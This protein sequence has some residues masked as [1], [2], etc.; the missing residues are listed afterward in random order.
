MNNSMKDNVENYHNS[1]FRGELINSKCKDGSLYDTIS[2]GTFDDVYVGDYYQMSFLD[3]VINCRIAGFDLFYN[4]IFYDIGVLSHHAVIVPDEILMETPMHYSYKHKEYVET[5]LKTMFLPFIYN[6]LL[7]NDRHILK[8]SVRLM[9]LSEIYGKYFYPYPSLC[10][11]M[12]KMD[13]EEKQ[14]PL[15]RLNKD[16]ISNPPRKNTLHY[17]FWIYQNYY[18]FIYDGFPYIRLNNSFCCGIRPCWLIG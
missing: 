13:L 1:K 5:S 10:D 6:S 8:N 2:D 7:E 9:N 15:F 16:L 17:S 12:K 18:N 4:K 14:F 11:D 3:K